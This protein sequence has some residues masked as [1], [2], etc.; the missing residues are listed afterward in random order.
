MSLEYQRTAFDLG[1][2]TLHPNDAI[3]ETGRLPVDVYYSRERFEAEREMF[4]RIWLNIAEEMEIPNAGDWVV[5]EIPIRSISLVIVRGKDMKIRAFYNNCAHRSMRLL[6]EEKGRGGKFVC[7]YHA[8]MYNASGELMNI[9]DP[10][11]FAHIDKKDHGLSPIQCDTWEGFIFVNLD[12]APAQTLQ[13]YLGPMAEAIKD[14]PFT[15]FPTR[16]RIRSQIKAN[17]KLALEAQ[18]EG[19]HAAIL[20]ARTVG[21]MLASKD[22][23]FNRP[24]SW[25]ALGPHRSQSVQ[26]NPDFEMFKGR[27]VQLFALS[28]SQQIVFGADGPGAAFAT[29][30]GVN[31]SRSNNWGNEQF[32]LYPHFVMHVSTG[33]WFYHRFWPIDEKTTIW[34]AT[35]HFG[36]VRSLRESF[37]NQFTLAFNRDTLTED[38]VAIEKQQVELPSG[39]RR[40][41]MFAS[42]AEMLCRHFAAVNDSYL[43]TLDEDRRAVA[44]E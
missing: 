24:L 28:N 38:N 10:E 37:G 27:S 16:V 22:N 20:H 31:K 18:T 26:F 4:G 35:Y 44:A 6:W 25:E 5:R 36:K 32:T 11:C 19:Y 13:E 41:L 12:P 7:P 34:E 29:Q 33:G 15:A 3:M 9:P 30:P 17:W 40:E 42:K 8:W 21:K 43:A 39:A 23:P 14:A 2:G 1:S